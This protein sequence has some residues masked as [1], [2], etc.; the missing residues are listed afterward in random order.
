MS[1]EITFDEIKQ[2]ECVDKCEG[3]IDTI[4]TDINQIEAQ[5]EFSERGGD[6]VNRATS[7]LGHKRSQIKQLHKRI[8]DLQGVTDRNREENDAKR[9]RKLEAKKAQAELEA[10]ANKRKE[11]KL[12]RSRVSALTECVKLFRSSSF[13]SHFNKAAKQVLEPHVYAEIQ[14]LA[15]SNCEAAQLNI[16]VQKGFTPEFLAEV[17]ERNAEQSA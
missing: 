11:M 2:I 6:W 9:Q 4:N 15:Q 8:R 5:L 10:T 1:G 7:A 12:E 3:L 16:L 17:V 13:L 14:G